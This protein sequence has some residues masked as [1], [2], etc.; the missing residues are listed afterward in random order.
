M[1]RGATHQT[2][3]I[4]DLRKLIAVAAG[5]D[6]GCLSGLPFGIVEVDRALPAGG[7]ALGSLHEF[8]DNGARCSYAVNAALFVAGILARL[9][10]PVLW[11]LHSRDLFAPALARVGLDLNRIVF[12]ETWK[13]ADILP[14]M[15]EGLRVPGLV[16]V[17]GELKRMP[18]T[19]SR[20]L[21]L[22]AEASGV[23]AFV[24]CRSSEGQNEANAAFSRWR[25]SSLPSKATEDDVLGRAL[26][27]VELM[28]CRGAAP[29]CWTL[30]ACD[31]EGRCA[32]PA[33]VPY[34]PFSSEER[35]QASA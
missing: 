29:Q 2:S 31:A 19:P 3:S 25:I 1:D 16:G 26:W 17:V 23:T 5:S 22:A 21:Q 15:E 10:G 12:C 11:C 4:A 28:R 27:R 14:A 13:D 20:R 32:L 6:N 35:W 8:A 30:E 7:L 18:L 9:P 34:R 24:I 33:D